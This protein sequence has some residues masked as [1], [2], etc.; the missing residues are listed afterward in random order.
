VRALAVLA[1]LAVGGDIA[2]GLLLPAGAEANPAV[3][4]LGWPMAALLRVAALY[5][6]VTVTPCTRAGNA[7]LGLAIAAGSLG[8][9]SN[10][11]VLL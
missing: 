10:L 5:V 7:L 2:T 8:L 6:I 9:G 3:V 11:S 1:T 4:A